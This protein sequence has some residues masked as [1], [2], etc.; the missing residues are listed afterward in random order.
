MRQTSPGST[1]IGSTLQGRWVVL[2]FESRL[3][4]VI[5]EWNPPHVLAFSGRFRPIGPAVARWALEAVGDRTRMVR[6]GDFE[7]QGPP[8]FVL[9]FFKPIMRRGMRTASKNL[10]RY[11]EGKPR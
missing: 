5:T 9:P 4:L 1:G 6:S 11:I 7:L 2:G 3:N 8:K 10:K